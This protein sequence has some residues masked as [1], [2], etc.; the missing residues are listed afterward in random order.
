MVMSK[1]MRL[2]EEYI[3][4]QD[5][6]RFWSGAIPEVLDA[7]I[8]PKH[9]WANKVPV[10]FAMVGACA[11]WLRPHQTRWTADGGFAWPAGYGGAGGGGSRQALPQFDWS[12]LLRYDEASEQW[13][14]AERMEGKRKLVL[15]VAAP[16]RTE[17]HDQA[18]VHTI[19]SPGSPRR[20]S[21]K[22]RRI[23]G[24][25]KSSGEWSFVAEEAL[26]QHGVA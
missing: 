6:P 16:T 8:G 13:A 22:E 20:P 1:G 5:D 4:V 2:F 11:N 19:W 15:R 3:S 18:V 24:F 25:R 9:L 21:E 7:C 14:L 10:V 12:I 23:L 26:A 17:I